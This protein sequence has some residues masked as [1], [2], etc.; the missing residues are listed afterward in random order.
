MR[1]FDRGVSVNL[2]QTINSLALHL[3]HRLLHYGQST[4]DTAPGEIFLRCRVCQLRSPGIATGPMRISR[5]LD[6]KLGRKPLQH[7]PADGDAVGRLITF[8]RRQR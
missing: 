2:K 6:G 3:K 5:R 4:I 7:V 8:E 1:S